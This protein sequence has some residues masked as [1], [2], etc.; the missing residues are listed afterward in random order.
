MW[1]L[2]N[3]MKNSPGSS[4]KSITGIVAAFITFDKI[5]QNICLQ[6]VSRQFILSSGKTFELYKEAKFTDNI[7][8]CVDKAGL[9]IKDI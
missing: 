6:K 7:L 3:I 5:L 8:G 1:R 2:I 9:K 4:D